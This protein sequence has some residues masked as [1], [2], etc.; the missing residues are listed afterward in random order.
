MGPKKWDFQ[1]IFQ[2]GFRLINI[3]ICIY[4]SLKSLLCN[5]LIKSLPIIL[6]MERGGDGFGA[7]TTPYIFFVENFNF[8]SILRNLC[9][10]FFPLKRGGDD[11]MTLK[12]ALCND[13]HTLRGHYHYS[14]MNL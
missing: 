9:R 8:L 2:V 1:R 12:S 5:D 11:L 6:T 13:D 7:I 10:Y 3:H 4:T 14:P